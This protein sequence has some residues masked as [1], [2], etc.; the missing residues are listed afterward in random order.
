[1]KIGFLSLPVPGHL[2]PMTALARELCGR[3]HEIVLI[4]V[5]DTE[6][7]VKGV[8]GLDFVPC[9]EKEFPRGAM[10][11][12]S[13]QMSVRRGSE[14]T[15]FT[16]KAIALMTEPL[17]NSLPDIVSKSGIEA[18]VLDTYHFYIELVPMKLQMPFVHLSNAMHFDYSGN[19]PLCIY[20]WP[21]ESTREAFE[22]NRRGVSAF[23]DVL[24]RNNSA[25]I[26]Y[27]KDAGIELSKDAYNTTSKLAWITQT[28]KEFDFQSAHWPAELHHTGPLVDESNRAKIDFPWNEL[29]GEPLIYASMGTLQN[30][31]VD[32]FREIG[33][34]TAKYKNTQL[35]LSIGNHIDKERIGSLAKNAI[36]V[37]NAP[38][39]EL[40]KRASLCITHAGCNTVLE[41][42]MYGV[43]QIAIPIAH[44][45]PG[46]AR[47]IVDNGTGCY[48]PLKNLT[49]KGLATL[50]DEVLSDGAY[51]ESVRKLQKSIAQ[52][53]GLSAAANLLE[54]AF[55]LNSFTKIAPVFQ[56]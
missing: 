55:G 11:D 24:G 27:A 38:Q 6:A 29:T 17:L 8:A 40:L 7:F 30:G 41:S 42:L 10:K 39:L 35:V 43:P 16:V 3:S 50:I 2:N 33:A 46:V 18:L 44:D 54:E 21:H 15:E 53:N 36:V 47:R 22:R 56:S 23:V 28:P 13:G 32:V 49:A 45:Q 51:V 12:V 5:L 25:A 26:A 9:C 34:A 14:A 4:S 37:K 48:M 52:Y 1:M 31:L 19:T 20:D